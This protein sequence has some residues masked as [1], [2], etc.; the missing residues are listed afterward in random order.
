MKICMSKQ[1]KTF[2]SFLHQYC[3]LS[4]SKHFNLNKKSSFDTTF[5]QGSFSNCLLIPNVD[6]TMEQH[7][8]NRK[9][10]L[11]FSSWKW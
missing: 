4:Y 10:N 1:Y 6:Q 2:E 3:V 11:K 9:W 5:S 7:L 8:S